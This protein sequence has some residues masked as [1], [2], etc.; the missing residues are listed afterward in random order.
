L[1]VDVTS[2]SAATSVSLYKLAVHMQER[3]VT[4]ADLLHCTEVQVL[5]GWMQ[6]VMAGC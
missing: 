1:L 5:M 6:N 2:G 4:I 3:V